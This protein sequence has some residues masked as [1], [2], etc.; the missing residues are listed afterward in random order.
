VAISRNVPLERVVGWLTSLAP[1]GVIEFI[2]KSDAMVVELLQL[3][4][5]IFEHYTE[6]HFVSCLQ[7]RAR[8]LASEVV[9]ASGRK[10]FA[11]ER[12]AGTAAI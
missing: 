10:L 3:R 7:Q 5:D 6:E 2:P 12:T 4:E 1:R 8:I 11:Y 9:S